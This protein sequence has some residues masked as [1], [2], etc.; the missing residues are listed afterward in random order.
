M[1]GAVAAAGMSAAVVFEALGEAEQELAGGGAGDGDFFD[2]AGCR[3]RVLLKP[4][5]DDGRGTG[6]FWPNKV[7]VGCCWPAADEAGKRRLRVFDFRGEDGFLADAG[8]AE[9]L[10]IR[11]GD[12]NAVEPTGTQRPCH[13]WRKT[14]H[15]V[16]RKNRT[17]ASPSP[18]CHTWRVPAW[19]E[20]FYKKPAS[21]SFC[22]HTW[23]K[24]A[25]QF[26]RRQRVGDKHVRG[27]L[28]ENI[29]RTTACLLAF[30]EMKRKISGVLFQFEN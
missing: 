28:A 2:D 30:H 13:T 7:A 5:A 4:A 3:G 21:Q 22:R 29:R 20:I 10:R 1:E 19:R 6:S 24:A 9:K 25:E 15:P 11:D 23:R 16:H 26:K 12:E 27:F 8:M 17:P 14:S 18:C